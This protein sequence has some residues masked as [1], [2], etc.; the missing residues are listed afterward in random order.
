MLLHPGLQHKANISLDD[1][2]TYPNLKGKWSKWV[3]RQTSKTNMFDLHLK[4]NRNHV[5]FVSF[6]DWRITV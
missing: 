4:K 6:T 1:I 5:T 2:A 3:R